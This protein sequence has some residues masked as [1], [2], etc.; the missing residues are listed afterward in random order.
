MRHVGTPNP[1]DSH[2][3]STPHPETSAYPDFC[4]QEAD[5]F[6]LLDQKSSRSRSALR[7]SPARACQREY[8]SV[9]KLSAPTMDTAGRNSFLAER[10]F[11]RKSGCVCRSS[12]A[13]STVSDKSLLMTARDGRP[14]GRGRRSESESRDR[15]HNFCR[16][17]PGVT[18]ISRR[19]V[20]SQWHY[21]TERCV[22]AVIG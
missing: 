3:I 21:D 10:P 17:K 16:S 5:K 2:A 13:Y 4:K 7:K 18:C 11:R 9:C 15:C 12:G 19:C 22:L 1:D 20:I 8:R 6:V 14:V